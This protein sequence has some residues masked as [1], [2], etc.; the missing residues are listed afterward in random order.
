MVFIKWVI[1]SIKGGVV[2]LLQRHDGIAWV[3]VSTKSGDY[4]WS[5]SIAEVWRSSFNVGSDLPTG[6]YTAKLAALRHLQYRL[7]KSKKRV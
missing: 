1:L 6:I 5:T 7:K 2:H 3:K 4:G